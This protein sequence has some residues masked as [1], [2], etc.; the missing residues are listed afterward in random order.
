MLAVP[1]D[2]G[3]PSDGWT[4]AFVA[5]K[6]ART[7]GPG[8]LCS[9]AVNCTSTRGMVYD[10]VIFSWVMKF[11]WVLQYGMLGAFAATLRIDSGTRATTSHLSVDRRWVLV[12]PVSSSPGR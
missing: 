5:V 7:S 8:W 3:R 4:A 1:P 12:P 10:P 9:A 6:F 11:P 2:S